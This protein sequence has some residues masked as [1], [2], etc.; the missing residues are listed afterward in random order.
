[1]RPPFAYW[2]D[3]IFCP[4]ATLVG[5][6]LTF[7]STAW[8]GVLVLGFVLFTFAEYWAHRL[9]LHRHF[10]HGTHE[11]HH[12][13]PAE[14]VVFRWWAIP[15][16][17]IAL[18]AVLPAA[19]V[20]GFALGWLWFCTCHHAMHQWRGNEFIRR[21]ARWHDLH[22]RFIRCNFGITQPFWDVVFRTYRSPSWKRS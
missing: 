21:C 18:F 20:S 10:Y 9:V 4:A 22:H 11:R 14:F 1:M 3:F 15:A 19:L 2:V 17:G 5:A 12:L 13:H 7:R 16:L 8:L 6:A